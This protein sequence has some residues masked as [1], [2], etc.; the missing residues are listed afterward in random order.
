MSM[1]LLPAAVAVGVVVGG[2]LASAV[3]VVVL[4][5]IADADDPIAP[6]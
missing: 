5:A 2:L 3:G 1:L 6:E 4:S